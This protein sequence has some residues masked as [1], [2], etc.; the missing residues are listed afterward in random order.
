MNSRNNE[1]KDTIEELICSN[2][3]PNKICKSCKVNEMLNRM[4]ENYS[5]E[6]PKW[7]LHSKDFK[8]SYDLCNFINS[9]QSYKLE[10]IIRSGN[11]DYLTLFFWVKE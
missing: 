5:N 11:S 9:N 6:E 10:S 3:D 1:T 7:T 2:C 8:F 4:E